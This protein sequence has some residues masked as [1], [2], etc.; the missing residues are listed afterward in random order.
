[1]NS[2]LALGFNP[3][4]PVRDSVK[5]A[6]RAEELGYESLWFHESLYQ[7]DV[8]SYLSAVL[9]STS[10]I[11]AGSGALNTFTRH[12][13]AA[14]ATFATLSEMS[15]GRV[16]LGLG[17]G[18]FPTVPNIGFKVFPVSETRPLARIRE[19]VEVVRRYLSGETLSFRGR[20]FTAENIKADFRAPPVPL[21]IA[22][23]SPRTQ[24]YAGAIA[25]G[26][27]L[28]PA[29]ATTEVT[30]SMVSHV[31]S[32]EAASGRTVDKA[33]YLLTSV[34]EDGERAREVVK[35]FY[36]FLYQLSDVIK[37]EV[38]AGYGVSG[39]Q[40][41]AFRSA[42]KRGDPSASSLV[43]TAAVDALAV[44]GTPSDARRRVE[45]YRSAGVDLPILMPIG[46]VNY[47]IEK[48]ASEI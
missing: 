10:R 8:V 21:Y 46:N 3:V 38:L 34:D 6:V 15:Q 33:S 14:A 26:A 24:R 42:W 25:D 30:G 22:T 45:E 4:L 7:R 5:I 1:M 35:R 28:S 9:Q 40:L 2:R 37:P 43:P 13:L 39:E 41:D 18:S 29:L 11:C 32:G 19:Y 16:R 31:R 48:L 17:L 20:F 23:L 47:A 44:A 12:P 36:F 27:I